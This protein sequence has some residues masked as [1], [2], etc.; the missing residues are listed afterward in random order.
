MSYPELDRMT[1][2]PGKMG[3][4]PCIRGIRITVGTMTGLLAAGESID[5]VLGQLLAK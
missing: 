1:L 5:S 4:K 2:D 3:G